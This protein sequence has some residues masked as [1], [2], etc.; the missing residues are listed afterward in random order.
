MTQLK[1]E[2]VK[3]ISHLARLNLS[4]DQLE[5]FSRQMNQILSF[6]EEL[7]G[8]NT[9]GIEP[10]SHAFQ[11]QTPLRPDEVHSQKTS[12]KILTQAPEAQAPYF[13]VPRVI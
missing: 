12:E 10:T 1:A 7:Q 8:L 2:E 9:E 4:E 13:V 11:Q 3:K 5:K 6:M